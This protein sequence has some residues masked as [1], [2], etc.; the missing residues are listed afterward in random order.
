MASAFAVLVSS[1]RCAQCLTSTQYA[2]ACLAQINEI[3]GVNMEHSSLVYAPILQLLVAS[4]TENGAVSKITTLSIG[5]QAPTEDAPV[6][7]GIAMV[8]DMLPEVETD[9]EAP[10][11]EYANP[12]EDYPHFGHSRPSGF[13]GWLASMFGPSDRRH[14]AGRPCPGKGKFRLGHAAAGMHKTEGED[15]MASAVDAAVREAYPEMDGAAPGRG[16]HGHHHGGHRHRLHHRKGKVGC[17]MRR[18]G[19]FLAAFFPL[20]FSLA[21]GGLVFSFVRR[22]LIKRSR[23]A[24]YQAV[25]T[26]DLVARDSE[27]EKKVLDDAVYVEALPEYES[28]VV[29]VEAPRT[30]EKQ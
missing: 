19:H 12:P 28:V 16:H 29:V 30:D 10:A 2:D 27:V 25:E 8:H 4:E 1:S 5:G 13:L 23:A 3:E 17:A 18:F 11:A 6:L 21:M 20:F 9:A 22:C 15:D 24:R 14:R 26:E 7:P